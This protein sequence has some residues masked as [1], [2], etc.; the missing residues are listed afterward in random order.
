MPK[1]SHR[2][3]I[4]TEGMR[5]VHERSFA[6]ASV[7]DIV[8]AAGVPQGSFTN[9]FTSKD[10][11]GLEILEM[12]CARRRELMAATLLNEELTPLSRLRAYIDATDPTVDEARMKRGCLIG[13]F[14]IEANASSE[15]IRER[16]S[17]AF[18]EVERAMESVLSAAVAAGEILPSINIRDVAGFIVESLQGAILRAKAERSAAPLDRFRT[19]L[20]S[21]ILR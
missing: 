17:A 9:H 1:V 15:L 16:V 11:F 2:E 7:R 10:A 8:Q 4:L 21:S 19:V 6:S 14:S 5:V 20:F 18:R 3:K 13:N 12:Y